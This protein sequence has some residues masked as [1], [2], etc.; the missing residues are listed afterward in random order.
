MAFDFKMAILYVSRCT[1]R[2][3]SFNVEEQ[4]CHIK[5]KKNQTNTQ[6]YF[7]TIFKSMSVEQRQNNAN[8]DHSGATCSHIQLSPVTPL[9]LQE[10]WL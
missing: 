7:G 2:E 5:E 10:F 3:G 4:L 9:S 1:K 6:I 8:L